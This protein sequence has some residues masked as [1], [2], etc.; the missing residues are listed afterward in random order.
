MYGGYAGSPAIR[1]VAVGSPN[2]VLSQL[3]FQAIGAA[4]RATFKGAAFAMEIPRADH[5]ASL[6]RLQRSS[7]VRSYVAKL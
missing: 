1:R 2:G 3:S 7:F 4:S 5:A 6:L